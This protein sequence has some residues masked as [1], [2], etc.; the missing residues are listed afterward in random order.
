MKI[1]SFLIASAM[2]LVGCG[3]GETSDSEGSSQRLETKTAESKAETEIQS[4]ND[5][6]YS[7]SIIL[8]DPDGVQQITWN[9]LMPEGEELILAQLYEEY[10]SN[11]EENMRARQQRLRDVGK[12]SLNSGPADI[13]ALI[14]EGSAADT[15][16]QVGTF[17]V[18]DDLDGMDIRLPG[19]V[20]P[21]SFNA[22]DEYTEFLFVP[23]PGACLHTPPPPPNQIV[24]VKSET[25]VKVEDIYFPYWI[26]GSMK[27]GKRESDLANSA[28]ELTLSKIETYE[29]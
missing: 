13:T 24:Y 19:Y 12:D 26:E 8:T 23:Q 28:Y 16:D 15:M 2:L 18:V 3:D 29:F 21:L 4:R 14:A 6:G 1:T 20:V 10:F 5:G 17:N 25:A 7:S 9:D 22:D 27:T 11:L